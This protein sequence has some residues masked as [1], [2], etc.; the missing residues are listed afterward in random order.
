V[1][2]LLAKVALQR[3]VP[4][5]PG[6]MHAYLWA[7]EHVTRSIVP[8][9]GVVRQK[10]DVGLL[11]HRALAE[12]TGRT[13]LPDGPHVDIGAGWHFTI[14]LLFWQLGCERQALV[15]VQAY[16]RRDIVF[17]VARLLGSMDMPLPR[18]ALPKPD[19][20]DAL[21]GW[22]ARLGIAYLAPVRAALPIAD[23]AAGLVTS[24]EVLLHPTRAG[25]RSLF[26]EAARVLRPGGLFLGT[27]HLYDLYSNFDPRLSRFNFLRYDEA[28]WE[29]WFN[30]PLMR[31]NR[32]RASDYER[33]FDG[34][35]FRAEVWDVRRPTPDD[36]AE[37]ARITPGPQF[38]CYAAEDLAST[39]L[40]F[41][42]RRT[43]AGPA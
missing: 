34:L 37:L 18:R 26:E 12:V 14:P 20:P 41:V 39:D 40:F 31:Y 4:V 21:E 3:A 11:Y 38:A 27:I 1:L 2:K 24:T 8:T 7:Q 33:L 13:T 35:P 16:A 23:G 28:T 19:G 5:M 43:G 32:L 25:V 9:E 17:E 15:D 42:M 10:I 30:G 29:R 36:F 22:L 6:G